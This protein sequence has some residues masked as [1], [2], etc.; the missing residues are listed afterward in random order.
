[1]RTEGVGPEDWRAVLGFEGDYEISSYGNVRALTYRNGTGAHVLPEPK[2]VAQ[3]LTRR[4]YM[5]VRLWRAGRAYH[6]LVHRLVLEAFVGPSP[7][8][9]E[10]AHLDGSRT[11]NQPHNLAWASRPDN[12]RHKLGHGTAQR[13][14]RSPT[15]RLTEEQARAVIV[16]W[17]QGG[18]SKVGIARELGVSVHSVYQITAGTGWK[19]LP[20]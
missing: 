9:H 7:E 8:G 2:P 15:A 19:H 14:E 6:R 4:G 5:D 18:Q 16:A 3:S 12:H 10:A 17:K 11:N 13:G 1:V 20:R